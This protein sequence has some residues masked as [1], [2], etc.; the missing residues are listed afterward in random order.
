MSEDKK[1]VYLV[2]DADPLARY[3]ARFNAT[4]EFAL[5]VR[6]L[7]AAGVAVYR[8]GDVYQV[9][10]DG[11]PLSQA[12]RA[13]WFISITNEI[14]QLIPEDLLPRADTERE[15]WEIAVKKILFLFDPDDEA[16]IGRKGAED[17]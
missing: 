10:D 17:R 14:D 16:W 3:L 6:R 15:A 12:E 4:G 9:D 2:A 1:P 8:V 7:M 11:R 13:Q 5:A